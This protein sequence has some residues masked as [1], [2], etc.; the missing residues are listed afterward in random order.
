MFCFKITVFPEVNSVCKIISINEN[1]FLEPIS[2][3]RRPRLMRDIYY[4][5]AIFF[6]IILFFWGLPQTLIIRPVKM[7]LIRGQMTLHITKTVVN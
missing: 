6:D 1:G 3:I 4:P 2:D 5:W 7:C